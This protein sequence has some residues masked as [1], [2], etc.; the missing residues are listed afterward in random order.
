MPNNL[1]F[2]NPKDETEAY[3]PSDV[4]D[5]S[6][7]ALR[8]SRA[9]RS[10]LA[11]ISYIGP[12][13]DYPERTYIYTGNRPETVG[14]HGQNLPDI[15]FG[16]QHYHAELNRLARLLGIGYELRLT[17]QKSGALSDVFAVRLY[18]KKTRINVGLN[19]VGFGV[20]Q[21]LPILLE[22]CLEGTSVVLVEQPEIHLH[23]SLQSALGSVLAAAVS[24]RTRRQFIIE[25]HSEH[26]LLRLQRLIRDN[27]L[28]SDKLRILF[29]DKQRGGSTV[30]ELRVAPNGDLLD[31]WP[32]GFFDDAFKEVFGVEQ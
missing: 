12:L 29:V 23:P 28:A 4:G 13:R 8:I 26:I 9:I 16:E 2:R 32:G 1:I 17:R 31:H 15:L 24:G 7:I 19:D 20:S 3:R 25:T 18:D 30:S 5:L 22:S 21:V 14:T 10:E 6:I 27:K 11:N